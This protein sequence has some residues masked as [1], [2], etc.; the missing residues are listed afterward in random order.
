MKKAVLKKA[1]LIKAVLLVCFL[2]ALP[3]LTL[4]AA[5]PAEEEELFSPLNPIARAARDTYLARL[6]EPDEFWRQCDQW[7]AQVEQRAGRNPSPLD[8]YTLAVINYYRGMLYTEF[9]EDETAMDCFGE[10]IDLLEGL[11]DQYESSEVQRLLAEIKGQQLRM[12]GVGYIVLNS[13][14][15]EAHINRSLKY[16]PDNIR[17]RILQSFRYVYGPPLLVQNLNR[18]EREYQEYAR[19]GEEHDP[20]IAY[21]A[22]HT[23]ALIREKRERPE[24]AIEY[25]LKA[26]KIYPGNYYVAGQLLKMGVDPR[27]YGYSVPEVLLREEK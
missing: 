3:V 27:E 20:W 10:S 12:K 6:F 17:T 13:L 19:Y 23:L 15:V 16:N 7:T 18:S 5:S 26:M 1:V 25:Y 22:Y 8:I 2:M 21:V 14:A 11:A 24:A 9:E 4:P